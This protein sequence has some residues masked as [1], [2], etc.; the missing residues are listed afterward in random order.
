MLNNIIQRHPVEIEERSID[1]TNES[2]GGMSFECDEDGAPKFQCEAARLNYEYAIAHPELYPVEYN[3]F[4]RW[5][6]TII[7]PAHGTCSCGETVYLTDEYMG[8]CQCTRCGSWYNVFGQELI[9][10]AYWED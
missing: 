4:K 9:H 10:P 1:F 3:V 6:R 8:A 5:A 2:G 7:E